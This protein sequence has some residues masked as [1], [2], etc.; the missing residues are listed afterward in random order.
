MLIFRNLFLYIKVAYVAEMSTE[1]SMLTSYPCPL[2]FHHTSTCFQSGLLAARPTKLTDKWQLFVE[3][4]N[5][6]SCQFVHTAQTFN[7]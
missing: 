2:L 3:F 1:V 4:M 5:S 7:N 6:S